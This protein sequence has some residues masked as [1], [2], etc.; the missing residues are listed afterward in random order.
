[1]PLD[2]GLGHAT[3]CIPIIRELE[4]QGFQVF[5][6]A[7]TGVA[8]LLRKEFP[9]IKILPLPGYRIGYAKKKLFFF[10]RLLM[11]FPKVAGAIQREHRWLQKTI[12]QNNIHLVISDNRF[13]LYSDGAHC[14][15]M[16]HQLFIK[17]GNSFT[18]K[19][20]QK[21]NYRFINKFDECWVP[22]ESG[23]DNLA[24]ELSH[25]ENLPPVP[26][27]YIGSLSRFTQHP[28]ETAIDLLMILSGPEPQRSMLEEILLK[29]INFSGM[30]AVL[31]RGLPSDHA[32]EKNLKGN[33]AVYE[34]LPAQEL[35]KLILSAKLVI[36]R[37]GYSTVMDLAALQQKAILIPTPGQAE[38][39]YLAK[40]LSEKKYC[41]FADQDL[42]D[43]NKM[44]QQA[45]NFQFVPYPAAKENALTE[46]IRL[47]K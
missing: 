46:I 26:V 45:E 15:F 47:L 35:N 42:S 24:H 5:I 2:W 18:E 39:E 10:F 9:A 16:T 29:K 3:R 14:I 40:Y 32:A 25:P 27:K 31:V 34:H 13:G 22:D 37:S 17:T 30:R 41:L 38:Q 23:A 19:I 11:Q 43:I 7:E 6:G 28:E 8:A 1:M 20:A 36:A 44:I 12:Q 21:I 4:A 33:V